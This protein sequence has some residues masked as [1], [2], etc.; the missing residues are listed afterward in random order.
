[1]NLLHICSY[2]IGNKL[3]SNLIE[4]LSKNDINQDIFIPIKSESF[5]G[6]NQLK[7]GETNI[8]Y[9]YKNILNKSD[10]FLYKSKIKKQM[11]SVENEILSKKKIDIIHAHTI[12]SDGGTAYELHKKYGIEYIVNV[13]N[14]DINFFYKY[15]LHL[16]SYMYK[17]LFNSKK[18]VFVS[19]AYKNKVMKLFSQRILSKIQDKFEVIPN[20]IDDYWF[21][22]KP[23][24]QQKVNNNCT[25]LLFVGKVD[26]NKNLITVIK[27]LKKLVDGGGNVYLNVVGNGPLLDKNMELSLKLGVKDKINYLGYIK[28]KEEIRRIMN[29]SDIFIL[30]SY[31]ETFGLVYIEAMSG[32]IPVIYS[33]GQ[34]IDGFFN[35]G[36]VGYSIKSNDINDIVN[37]INKIS[38]NYMEISRICIEKSYGFNWDR[39]SKLYYSL[40]EKLKTRRAL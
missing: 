30:P 4:E 24:N 2:Y 20:G 11:K 14:T 15:A 29:E 25:N 5:I 22:N 9:H 7:P 39:I 31:T 33:K 26:K 21:D 19:Y 3:Y 17:I 38:T 34:G 37:V 23:E 18:I 40:Y 27:V 36:E 6:V 32:G 1:M 12:F 13:R 10:R 35:E 28:D 16:R 8:E